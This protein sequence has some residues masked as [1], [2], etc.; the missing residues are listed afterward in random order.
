MRSLGI[1]ALALL[2]LASPVHAQIELVKQDVT[3]N[4]TTTETR[5]EIVAE[6][7]AKEDTDTWTLPAMML[8][9]QTVELDGQ[10]V[11]TTPD[12]QLG[13]Y[14]LDAKLP[15]V[16]AAGSTAVMRILLQGTLDCG[17]PGHPSLSR[18]KRTLAET[19]L[20]PSSPGNAWYLI[21]IM[22]VLP[23]VGDVVVKVPAALTVVSGQG[24]AVDVQ[25]SGDGTRTWTF[26]NHRPTELFGVYAG[27]F[28]KVNAAGT[29]PVT[30][31]F[32]DNGRNRGNMQH[33][34]DLA[35]QVLPV[36]GQWFGFADV[37]DEAF[38][39]TVPPTFPFGGMGLMGKVLWGEPVVD[40]YT[41]LL[42]QGVAHELAHTWWGNLSTAA[43]LDEGAFLSE[44]FAEY[45]GWRALGEVQG[46][47][48]RTRGCR[49]NAVWYMYR[50]P[51]ND[52]VAILGGSTSSPV[53]IH[54]AYHKGPQVVRTFAETVGEEAFTHAL[55][56][57]LARGYG[58]QTVAGLIADVRNESQVD[59]TPLV[60]Q[61]C[62]GTG[63]PKLTVGFTENAT[64]V[65]LRV[66]Q[67]EGQFTLRLPVRFTWS[68]ATVVDATMDVVAGENEKTFEIPRGVVHVA[69]DPRWTAVR[70]IQPALPGDVNLDNTLD[71]ADVMEI[72]LN[73]GGTIPDQRRKDG[74]YEPLAD[75]TGDEQ[76]DDTDLTKVLERAAVP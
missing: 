13:A 42:E 73:V 26:R 53:Y 17:Y 52:D 38:I 51:D 72:A 45:S 18:C 62:R 27:T 76:V 41:Y 37:V 34:V 8:P 11:Q 47:D 9:I 48:V 55:Q 32:H 75:V 60:E 3:V 4:L 25:D 31:Y 71:M 66:N 33:A 5:I 63:F 21:N 44:S 59:I 12:E 2:A 64:G 28:D 15:F 56:T 14:L 36:Y 30:G 70:Q 40:N 16:M 29:I 24:R 7:R 69:V 65:T 10:P 61:W 1:G 23:F 20:I 54:A 50:R 67:Y 49:M 39:L 57:F 46:D 68:N 43:D 22:G 6:L 58:T 19:I 35:S 74:N